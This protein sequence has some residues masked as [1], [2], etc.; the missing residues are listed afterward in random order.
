MIQELDKKE[1]FAIE[2]S[3]FGL[4]PFFDHFLSENR[5]LVI[6][7][8]ASEWNATKNWS[9]KKYLSSNAGNVVVRLAALIHDPNTYAKFEAELKESQKIQRQQGQ[10]DGNSKNKDDQVNISTEN[11]VNDSKDSEPIKMIKDKFDKG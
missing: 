3:D 2:S 9:D 6:R 7:Q 11:K 1:P 5:P 8:Y 4:K 10:K